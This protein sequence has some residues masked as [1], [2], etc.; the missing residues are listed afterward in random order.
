MVL[1]AFAAQTEAL[2]RTVQITLGLPTQPAEGEHLGHIASKLKVLPIVLVKR[3][4]R[5]ETGTAQ[6]L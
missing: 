4:E 6:G 5:L 2:S 3:F 1:F